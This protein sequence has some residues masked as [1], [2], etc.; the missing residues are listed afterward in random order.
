MT[1]NAGSVLIIKYFLKMDRLTVLDTKT[2]DLNL[3]YC[4]NLAMNPFE[5]KLCKI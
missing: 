3:L 5:H 2:W 1:S 4:S